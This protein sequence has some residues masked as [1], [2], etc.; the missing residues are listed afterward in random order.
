VLSIVLFYLF[1]GHEGWTPFTESVA[2]GLAGEA[3]IDILII[4]LV[5]QLWLSPKEAIRRRLGKRGSILS[6]IGIIAF[7]SLTLAFTVHW[8]PDKGTDYLFFCYFAILLSVISFGTVPGLIVALISCFQ[9]ISISLNPLIAEVKDTVFLHA[10]LFGVMVL[11][12][13]E[14]IK[15]RD[16]ST[17]L[18]F[19]RELLE[20][21]EQFMRLLAHELKTP[22]TAII[23]SVGLLAEEIKDKMLSR[24]VFNINRSAQDIDKRLSDLLDAARTEA[25]DFEL[26]F[27]SLEPRKLLEG[28]VAS[29]QPLFMAKEQ[30]LQVELPPLPNIMGDKRRLSQAVFNILHNANKFT[31]PGGTITLRARE[32]SENIII[33]IEDTGPGIAKEEMNK[34]FT[35]YFRAKPSD[36]VPGFGLGLFLARRIIELHKGKIWVRSELGKGSTFFIS[37]PLRVNH[38]GNS[39]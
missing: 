38:E 20:E 34:L 11:I 15:A 37:L 23:S 26:K 2:F 31:P 6:A 21:R 27:E 10:L 8:S 30:E 3:M 4:Y 17:E 39:Y 29:A 19:E 32:D 33:E 12:C 16:K 25:K 36:G 13:S 28:L 18:E 14:L 5:C 1:C 22:L 9:A 35:P 7:L 24:L